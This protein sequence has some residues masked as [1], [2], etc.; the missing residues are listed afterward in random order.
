MSNITWLIKENSEYIPQKDYNAG[1]YS[2]EEK[3]KIEMQVW[4]NRFGITDSD[5]LVNP[6]LN[7]Y[8][9]SLEDSVL[10]EFCKIVI[11]DFD[12]VSLI[13]KDQKASARIMKT[14]SGKANDGNSKDSANRNNFV[15]IRFEFDTGKYNLKENDL[16]NLFFEIVPMN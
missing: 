15:N 8:F 3:L 7:F 1:I 9:D 16:K 12:E 13:I 14:L 5:N 11:D 2:K 10:L 4:N 6:V